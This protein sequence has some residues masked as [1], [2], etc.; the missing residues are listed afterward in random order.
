[1]TKVKIYKAVVPI[2]ERKKGE[3]KAVMRSYF[4]RSLAGL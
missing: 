1:M 3:E 2:P 4:M